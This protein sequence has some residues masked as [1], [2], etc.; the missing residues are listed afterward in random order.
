MLNYFIAI[1]CFV[2]AGMILSRGVVYDAQ[3]ARIASGC[4]LILGGIFIGTAGIWSVPDKH[5]FTQRPS[6]YASTP[7]K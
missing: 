5:S 7:K 3:C 1:L 6:F 2:L 4:V